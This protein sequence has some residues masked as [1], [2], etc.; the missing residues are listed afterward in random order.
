LPGSIVNDCNER[1]VR[2]G[3]NV[4]RSAE[5]E[6]DENDNSDSG[7]PSS[8]QPAQAGSDKASSIQGTPL[9]D[10]TCV[11]ADIRYPTVLSLLNEAKEVT[12]KLIDA[13][14]PQVRASVGDKPRTH[15]K[16]ARQQFLA[17][18]KKKRPRIGMICKAIQQQL[19]RLKRNIGSI[20][21][22]IAC[23]GSLLAAGRHWYHKLLVVSELVRQQKNCL[24][25]CPVSTT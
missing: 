1:I 25:L 5:S 11:P 7:V 17:V 15:S 16:K 8:D 14:H 6:D 20:D 4:I 22:V 19:G 12:E 9:I 2:H 24:S 18:A 13:M 10:A 23:G 3:L 21:A